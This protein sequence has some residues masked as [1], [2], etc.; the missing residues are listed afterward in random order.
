MASPRDLVNR[1][2]RLI[3]G[4]KDFDFWGWIGERAGLNELPLMGVPDY[5]FRLGYWTGGMAAAAFFWQ[6]ITGL[7][8]LMYYEPSNPYGS[9]MDLIN[10][11]MYGKLLLASHLYGAYVMI[12]L[13]FVHMFRNYFVGAY[14]RPRELQWML[15]VIMGAITLGI[16]FFGYSL[17]GDTLSV[18]GVDVA[19]GL[20]QG[21]PGGSVL[22]SIF[23]GNGGEL[24]QYTRVLAWHI[25]LAG[26]LLL[27]LML[28]L[29]LAEQHGIMP[30]PR[31]TGYRAPVLVDRREM[32][33]WWP[34]NFL[35]MVAVL[36][37]T[38]GFI[39]IIPSVL[40]MLPPGSIPILFSPTPG[41]PPTSPAAATIPPYPLWFFLNIYKIVDLGI[42]AFQGTTGAALAATIG[43]GIPLIFLFL[44]PLLD[45]SD[46]LHP[47]DRI[48]Y[49][50]VMVWLLVVWLVLLS[51]LG[52]LTPGVIIPV[53]IAAIIVLPP[54][55]VIITGLYLARR[56]WVNSTRVGNGVSSVKGSGG[57]ALREIVI[58]RAYATLVLIVLT[59]V[60]VAILA[61]FWRI[62]MNMSIKMEPVMGMLVGVAMV[63]FG[64]IVALYRYIMYPAPPS[65]SG[66]VS[67][68]S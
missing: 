50:I 2:N 23:F 48:G 57:I 13:V 54:T 60:E 20:L 15:G 14:K 27:L 4:I 19:K 62:S 46:K 65:P 5:M 47:L 22:I 67:K 52:A 9:T 66:G 53:N 6:L 16:G 21:V 17:V 43:G 32:P 42:P 34:R 11:T 64:E 59:A 40:L 29:G 28:H 44:L 68:G 12:F 55:V 51:V 26:L 10:T 39:L 7:I 45:R 49:T 3:K 31:T 8:L 33:P 30:S 1:I 38:W 63:V 41:P 37:W 58:R 35:Y 24:Q 36:F 61:V 18:D 56:T 25:T